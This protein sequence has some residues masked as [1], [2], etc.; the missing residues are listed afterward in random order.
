MASLR[1]R[2]EARSLEVTGLG[3]L[4]VRQQGFTIDRPQ[5]L[6]DDYLLLRFYTPMSILTADGLTDGEP[7]DCL[8][9]DPTFPQWYTGRGVGFIDDWLRVTPSGM[10]ELVC[11][12]GVPLNTLFRPRKL[13]FFSPTLEAIGAELRRR[14]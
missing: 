12:Y 1:G 6:G 2:E 7:G 10:P 8:L 9:Y 13:D 4:W 3:V 14:E 11:R 5:G